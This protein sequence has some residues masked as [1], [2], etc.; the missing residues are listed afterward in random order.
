LRKSGC[1]SITFGSFSLGF[2]SDLLGL[3]LD[4]RL[5]ALGVEVRRLDP[6]GFGV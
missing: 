2:G 6:L 3:R 1:F 4:Y 5:L